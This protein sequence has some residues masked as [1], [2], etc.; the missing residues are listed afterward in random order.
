[1]FR[2]GWISLSY[3][4]ILVDN[5]SINE[6]FLYIILI[7]TRFINL[8]TFLDKFCYVIR[9]SSLLCYLSLSM[10]IM[11][12]NIECSYCWFDF[13]CQL[14]YINVSFYNSTIPYQREYLFYLNNTNKVCESSPK[15]I[16]NKIVLCSFSIVQ[17]T[18]S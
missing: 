13:P 1:M 5:Q 10:T 11:A 7:L 9:Y 8:H 2:L 12:I 4:R 15:I 14:N 16:L 3:V 17:I 6:V 18:M